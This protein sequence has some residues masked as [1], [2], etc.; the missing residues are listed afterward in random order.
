MRGVL[1]QYDLKRGT[2]TH[3]EYDEN[4]EKIAIY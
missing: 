2:L 3:G 1:T 4:M